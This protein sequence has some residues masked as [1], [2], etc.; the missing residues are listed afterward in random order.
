MAPGV[1]ARD[2]ERRG[3]RVDREHLR[4]GRRMRD[5][6]CDRARAG[7]EVDHPAGAVRQALERKVDEKLGLRPRDQHVV[8]HLEREA[9]ELAFAREVGHRL[10]GA[11]Q[12]EQPL[13]RAHRFGV[14]RALGVG[15]DPRPREPQHVRGEHLRLDRRQA[16]RGEERGERCAQAA[17][18]SPSAASSSA[19]CSAASASTTSSR[20]PSITAAIR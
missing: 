14:E 13:D 16:A 9:V 5:G 4:V 6:H 17:A 3:R 11:A 8:G 2:R 1:L 20:S 10:T 7:A 12:Q 19:W 18:L 15:E